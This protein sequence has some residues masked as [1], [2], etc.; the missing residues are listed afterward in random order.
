MRS[1]GGWDKVLTTFA[2][3]STLSF[4]LISDI[5]VSYKLDS[6]RYG[7]EVAKQKNAKY[8]RKA[9]TAYVVTNVV[10]S[11]LAT[12]FDAFRDYDE[13]DK[14]EEYLLKL[15]L[16]NMAT[17]SS[18]INKLPYVNLVVSFATGFTPSR[19][20]TDW[21]KNS[22]E[23]V[24]EVTK[25]VAGEGSGEKALEKTLRALSDGTGVAGYNLYRDV[26]AFIELFN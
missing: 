16:E 15:M 21:M 2:S 26:R 12:M 18:F 14:D 7:K 13:E 23:A 19:V 5:F 8:M 11:M 3:E 9:I 24:K 20:E 17:N 22:T 6:R 25:F 1:K 10:T 4:N